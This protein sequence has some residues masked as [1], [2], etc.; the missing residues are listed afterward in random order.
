[1]LAD[2]FTTMPLNRL[3]PRMDV[4]EDA[5]DYTVK[6]AL[7]G[8][9]RGAIKSSFKNDILTVEAEREVKGDSKDSVLRWHVS[10]MYHGSVYRSV[11]FPRRSVDSDA[12]SAGFEN[13]VL[14]IKLPKTGS[15]KET[16]QIN[17]D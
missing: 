17:I 9:E 8:I 4:S 7:P 5:T 11:R 15:A 1:M 14:T 3:E 2:F 6:V 12:I 16:K 10:E 13:G